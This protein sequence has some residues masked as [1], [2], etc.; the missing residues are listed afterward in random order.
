[1]HA[2]E[3]ETR[4]TGKTTLAV[5]REVARRLPRTGKARII[6]LIADDDAEDR[7]WRLGAYE[8]FMAA[9]SSED[10]VYDRYDKDR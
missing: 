7:A 6:M 9:D 10:S 8:Q 2:V 1:M 4:L 3:F 5:P